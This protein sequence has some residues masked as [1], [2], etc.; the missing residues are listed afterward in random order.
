MNTDAI[1][2]LA[3]L[4]SLVLGLCLCLKSNIVYDSKHKTNYRLFGIIIFILA[5]SSAIWLQSKENQKLRNN[6]IT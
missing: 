1:F 2:W 4:I 6:I 5:I 3:I